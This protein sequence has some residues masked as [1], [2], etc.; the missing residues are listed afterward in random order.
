MFVGQFA[1]LRSDSP[2]RSMTTSV[3]NSSVSAAAAAGAASHLN[4]DDDVEQVHCHVLTG[5][6]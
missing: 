4:N 2:V 6:Q 3:S 1:G 5:F